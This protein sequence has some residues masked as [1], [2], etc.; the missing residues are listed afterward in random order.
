MIPQLESGSLAAGG[1][2]TVRNWDGPWRKRAPAHR[3]QA[4][5]GT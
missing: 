5:R 1:G 4:L 3:R 2:S